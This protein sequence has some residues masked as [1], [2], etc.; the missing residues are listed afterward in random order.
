[1]NI[2]Q[3][4]LVHLNTQWESEKNTLAKLKKE[5]E[6]AYFLLEKYQG[7]FDKMQKN[8]GYIFM[9]YKQNGNVYTFSDGATFNY[10]TQ[11]F[12]FPAGQ[13]EE[14][15]HV[16]H[17]SFGE[18][19]LSTKIDENFVHIN[20][21][22]VERDEKYT[23]RKILENKYAAP[24]MSTSDSIQLMEIFW[25]VLK[26]DLKIEMI[27]EAGG[28][29][30][31]SNGVYFRDSTLVAEAYSQDA[32]QN[33]GLTIYR[34][35]KSNTLALRVT[36]YGEKMIP[37]DFEPYRS[38]FIK[39]KSK[40]PDLT[41]IDFYTGIK[42]QHHAK[43]WLERLKAI[44]PSWFKKLDEQAKLLKALNGVKI[45]NVEFLQGKLSSKVPMIK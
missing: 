1:M 25:A 13:R 15:F 12:T 29:M 41:E 4:R 31:L 35:D 19:V 32:F 2:E 43:I 26:H 40:N 38:A 44:V 24:K 30:G 10:A 9:D 5:M 23:Y 6:E 34:A 21:S 36:A 33:S 16:Y 18:R 14:V 20:F 27:A 3:N 42:A 39:L 22:S 37:S 11:D 45:K 8:L 17:I 7:L 28:I